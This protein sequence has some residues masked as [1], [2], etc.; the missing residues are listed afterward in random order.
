MEKLNYW[1]G[2]VPP[3][4]GLAVIVTAILVF[5]M[6]M[7]SNTLNRSTKPMVTAIIVFIVVALWATLK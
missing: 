1:F 4:K 7:V 5:I 6:L 3:N 2:W